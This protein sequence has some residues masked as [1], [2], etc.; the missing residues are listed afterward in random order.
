MISKTH[1]QKGSSHVITIVALVVALIGALG[2]VFWQNFIH[3][4]P[5]AK[6]VEIVKT[7]NQPKDEY[8]GWKT[9]ESAYDYSIRYPSEWVVV[10]ETSNDG[11][12]IRNFDPA[13]RPAE[14]LAN[15]KNYPKDYINIRVLKTLANDGVFNGS[16]ATE[17]YNKLGVSSTSGMAPGFSFEPGDITTTMINGMAAKKGKTVFT[18]TNENIF[19][20]KNRD[21]YNINLYPYGISGNE[22]VKKI[23]NSFKFWVQQP[24]D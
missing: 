20:L 3:K 6:E 4:E 5:V 10:N 1:S 24:E 8:A 23:L 7:K 22:D 12:Y 15:N 18:E 21:L 13:S 2:F 16:T 9:Y 11:P 17:W 19:L 14:D